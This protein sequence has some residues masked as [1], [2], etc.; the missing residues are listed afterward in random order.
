M[1]PRAIALTKALRLA[2]LRLAKLARGFFVK[3]RVQSKGLAEFLQWKASGKNRDLEKFLAHYYA[4]GNKLATAYVR[5][6]RKVSLEDAQ[7]AARV[8]LFC[9]ARKW[10]PSTSSFAYYSRFWVLKYLKIEA[11]SLNR[12][13]DT[14]AFTVGLAAECEEGEGWKGGLLELRMHELGEI[15]TNQG[16]ARRMAA[17]DLRELYRDYEIS[18]EVQTACDSILAGHS[19]ESVLALTG[20]KRRDLLP[21]LAIIRREWQS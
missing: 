14:V 5:A 18:P 1:R 21:T 8:G 3:V 4:W 6:Q 20:L 9:A 17:E 10:N 19:L 11:A 2:K 7:Q 13:A 12:F 16:E 15:E